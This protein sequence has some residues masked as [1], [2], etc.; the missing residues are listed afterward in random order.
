[1]NYVTASSWFCEF[2]PLSFDKFEVSPN[3]WSTVGSFGSRYHFLYLNG[4]LGTWIAADILCIYGSF[5]FLNYADLY[6]LSRYANANTRPSVLNSEASHL[7]EPEQVESKQKGAETENEKSELRLAQLQH[8][9]P[10][11]E[12]GALMHLVEEVA[13]EDEEDQDTRECKNLFKNM[14]IF[15]SREV[16]KTFDVLNK[17]HYLKVLFLSTVGNSGT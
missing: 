9:L 17:C 10:S 3:T 14:K 11:N 5:F 2:P 6:A 16:K 15:L 12:A 13:G 7:A 1:M 8:Q 4:T